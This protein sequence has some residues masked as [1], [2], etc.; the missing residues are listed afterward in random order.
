MKRTE[1]QIEHIVKVANS[2]KVIKECE[3][4]VCFHQTIGRWM[5]V[6]VLTADE[7]VVKRE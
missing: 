1:E 7:K 2:K 4:Q 3:P 6:R 5:V